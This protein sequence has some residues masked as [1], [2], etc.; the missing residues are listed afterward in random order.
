MI[1]LDFARARHHAL[2]EQL[3]ADDPDLDEETLADT[4][5]GL[6]D[7]HEIIA[8]ILRAALTDEA[9]ASGL[10]A[11]IC[12][13]QERQER[14]IERA[15][16]R[17]QIAREAMI[18]AAIK[19]ITAPDLTVTL[20]PGTPGLTII[21]ETAIPETYWEARPPR[22]NRQALLAD[23]KQGQIISGAL[24]SNLQPVISVRTK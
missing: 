21:D 6:T 5:E 1:P 15:T 16:K 2:R 3:L 11:R 22:L 9:L 13:M 18:E 17:R 12:D 7:L 20:R 4:L 23:L 10:K 19:K 24:L 8:T 14:L